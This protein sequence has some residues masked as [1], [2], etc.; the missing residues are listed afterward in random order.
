MNEASYDVRFWHIEERDDARARFRVR[1]TVAGGPPPG[2][3]RG[4]NR[5]ATRRGESFSPE[6]GLPQS[7]TRSERDVTCYEHADEFVKVTWPSA[8]GKS[9]VSLLE[10]LSRGAAGADTGPCRGA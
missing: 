8:A 1:W 2:A 3:G 6:T 9:R 7:L 4:T 10:T 5:P